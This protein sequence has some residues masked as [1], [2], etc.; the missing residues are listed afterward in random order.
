M[1]H[2]V[3]AHLADRLK[4]GLLCRLQACQ[5]REGRHLPAPWPRGW[6]RCT[7]GGVRWRRQQGQRLQRLWYS[8]LYQFNN[9]SGAG[10][11]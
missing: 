4:D 1:A 11:W 3:N 2:I 10:T 8:V 6:Q 7:A 9:T 5:C